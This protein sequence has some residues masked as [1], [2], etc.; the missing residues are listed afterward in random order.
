[1]ASRKRTVVVE[2]FIELYKAEPCLW[3]VKS[4]DYHNR[5]KR[6]V[7]YE[8]LKEKLREIEPNATKED[9]LKKINS[10]RSN[11]RKEKKKYKESLKS[12]ASADDVYKP[13]LW[14]YHLFDFLGD[15]NTPRQ[16][17]S[18][19][20]DVDGEVEAE[21]NNTS[22]DIGAEYNVGD[23]EENATNG[24]TSRMD[25]HSQKYTQA[26]KSIKKKSA[27]EAL[28][29]DVLLSVRDHFK[30]P[31]AIQSLEDRY[32]LLGRTIAIKLRT[33]DNR[34]RL[35]AE[36][37]INDTLFEAEMGTLNNHSSR[38]CSPSTGNIQQYERDCYNHSSTT[39]S[40]I[41]V[42]SPTPSPTSTASSPN[43]LLLQQSNIQPHSYSQSSQYTQQQPVEPNMSPSENSTNNARSYFATYTDC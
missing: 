42:P 38:G 27:Q 9:V 22:E 6:A 21:N 13:A 2:E 18:N 39:F 33:L 31:A 11:V 24:S 36:K 8:K 34:Q 4:K 17:C 16:S 32:D 26:N 35:F 25:E 19:L 37:I 14:Y 1:M 12:G 20:D 40:P 7:A 15:E 3:L 28:T 23:S 29:T 30:R 41:F 10:L 5:N 43:S